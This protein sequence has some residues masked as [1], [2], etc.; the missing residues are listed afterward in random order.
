MYCQKCGAAVTGNY[1]CVCAGRNYGTL[2]KSSVWP[3]NAE[4]LLLR[5]PPPRIWIFPKIMSPRLAG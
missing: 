4:K 2:L 3:S 5:L 1:C